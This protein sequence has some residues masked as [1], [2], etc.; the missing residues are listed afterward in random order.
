MRNPFNFE[1]VPLKSPA[2]CGCQS[3]ELNRDT[4]EFET[5]EEFRGGRRFPTRDGGSRARSFRAP[6]RIMK[7]P[8]RPPLGRPKQ[9]WVRPPYRG[10]WLSEPVVENPSLY[11]EPSG[12][13][14]EPPGGLESIRWVQDCLNQ[15]LGLQLPVT[16]VMGPETRS[17]VR[18]FQR[19][20]R[21]RTS[22]IVGPDTEE[23]LKV[24]CGNKKSHQPSDEM[25][26]A[27]NSE[28]EG[29]NETWSQME[30][31]AEFRPYFDRLM[32]SIPTQYRASWNTAQCYRLP[33]ALRSAPRLGG[34]YILVWGPGSSPSTRRGPIGYVGK[35]RNLW[36][37]VRDYFWYARALG[38]DPR[39][40]AI[41]FFLIPDGRSRGSIELAHRSALRSAGLVTNQQ[42]LEVSE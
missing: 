19:Q 16:G 10:R 40:Y 3:H 18:S 35:A 24:A 15:A 12:A 22:G 1:P 20:Q 26:F 14:P 27:A 30:L 29:L 37:R 25:E 41:C 8:F 6:L 28:S 36:Q 2:N 17:A 32:T 4:A 11:R 7:K 42:E 31:P 9:P 13:E 38:V 39:N 23:A 21:L 33:D 34:L 5:E